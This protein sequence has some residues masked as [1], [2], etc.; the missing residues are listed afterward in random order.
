MSLGQLENEA[1]LKRFVEKLLMESHGLVQYQRIGGLREALTPPGVMLDYAGATPPSGYLACDGAAVSRTTYA[2]LFSAISTQ[3]GSGDGA[4]TFNLPNCKGRVAVPLDA[5]QAEFS[6]LGQASGEKAHVLLPGEMPSHTHTGAS[7]TVGVKFGAATNT[8]TTSGGANR[9]TDISAAGANTQN[10]N[11]S[12]NTGSAGSDGSH[13]NLQ[14]YI[15]VN[16]I[17]KV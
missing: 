7:L 17:I 3:Y 8:A 1:D 9:V 6:Y 15:T 5:S 16:R 2:A 11:P 12:G 13:N 10:F 4:T 14:P